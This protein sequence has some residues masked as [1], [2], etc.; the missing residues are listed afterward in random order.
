MDTR[1]RVAGIEAGAVE[2]TYD[3]DVP[4]VKGEKKPARKDSD[5][6]YHIVEG[7]AS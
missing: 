1:G 4:T 3:N 7:M 5:S 6:E 2:I